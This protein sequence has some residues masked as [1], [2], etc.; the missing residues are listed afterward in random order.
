M[1]KI[2]RGQWRTLLCCVGM[3]LGFFILNWPLVDR[4]DDLVFR[5]MYE[6][7]NGLLGWAKQYAEIWSGRVITHGT[8]V[9]LQRLP[10][11]CF[12]IVNSVFL[13]LMIF[14]GIR[15]TEDA[16]GKYRNAFMIAA[17]LLFL[18][19]FTQ[20]MLIYAVFWKAATVLYVWGL[21][22]VFFGIWPFYQTYLGRK[23]RIVDYV[24][25]CIGLIYCSN[26]EQAAPIAIAVAAVLTLFT[27]GRKNKVP[28]IHY[29]MI[30]GTIVLLLIS[31]TAK[32]NA[33][34]TLSE[35]L[36]YMPY[37]DSFSFGDKLLFSINYTLR[38]LQEQWA[39]LLAPISVIAGIVVWK[40]KN[41]WSV[42]LVALFP[43]LYYCVVYLIGK[44]SKIYTDPIE[45]QKFEKY[46]FTFT[47]FTY[48]RFELM[49]EGVISMVIGLTA[50]IILFFL[51]WLEVS[52]KKGL[53][54]GLFFLASFCDIAILGMSPSIY[55]SGTRVGFIAG[56][57]FLM[58]LLWLVGVALEQLQE[59][60]AG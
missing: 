12:Q 3:G 19:V 48:E 29:A 57:L 46:L 60:R 36:L 49:P 6:Q 5:S 31:V 35:A 56:F 43:A 10:N 14:F 42:K 25:A 54:M 51:I 34:R 33:E 53:L 38:F 4:Y 52:P 23:N 30:S 1:K 26:F 27:L 13:S 8:M 55:A 39:I 16:K 17:F 37:Y 50:F 15:Y 2:D 58:V 7:Q 47:E 9:L 59:D 32:G 41:A 44:Q 21:V 40:R 18:F 20:D 11:V 22:G 28:L 45:P 24:L